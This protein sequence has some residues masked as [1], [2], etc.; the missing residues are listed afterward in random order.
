MQSGGPESDPNFLYNTAAKQVLALSLHALAAKVPEQ[1]WYDT[2][3]K[4]LRWH[5]EL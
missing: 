3:S 4:L 5:V 1:S 2:V